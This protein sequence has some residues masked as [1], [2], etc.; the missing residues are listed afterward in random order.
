M[1]Y[2]QN[3]SS[4]YDSHHP[5][6]IPP[7]S[8]Q[9]NNHDYY[10][11]SYAMQH[12]PAYDD[13]HYHDGPMV[14]TDDGYGVKKQN[15]GYQHLNDGPVLY[16]EYKEERQ[17]C[18]DKVCCGCCTCFPRWL[19]WLCCILFFIIVALAIAVG[20]LAALFKVPEVEFKGIQGDPTFSLSGTSA[21]ISF[22]FD[23]SVNNQN[24]EG[25]TF[26]KIVANAY[27]P[28]YPDY[29]I[30]TGE[31]DNVEIAS[32]ATTEILFPFHIS[33]N[34][35]DS[36]MQAI[37]FDLVK[38]CGLTGSSSGSQV[39]I[40]YKVTPTL[41][42]IGIP[43]SVTISQS[44]NLPCDQTSI[45]DLSNIPALAS[46]ALSGGGLPTSIVNSLPTGL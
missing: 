6:P 38:K 7:H 1:A 25:I 11:N 41:K 40:D 34:V 18:C 12:M 37:L 28:G 27:Y 36:T 19:R 15:N 26:D 10:N 32:K 45:P 29:V 14:A 20:V 16:T 46:S 3:S 2:Y 33:L 42:I 44:A 22:T 24:V 17:S 30:G 31:K 13:G 35:T 43:I 4:G 39:T 5:S 21:N 9:Y 8:P 23:I